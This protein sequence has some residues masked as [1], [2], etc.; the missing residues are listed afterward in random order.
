M[1]GV[2]GSLL[3]LSLSDLRLGAVGLWMPGPIVPEE[4][5][6]WC[7]AKVKSGFQG[8]SAVLDANPGGVLKSSKSVILQDVTGKKCL[9]SRNET[10]HNVFTYI[11]EGLRPDLMCCTPNERAWLAAAEDGLALPASATTIG[12]IDF[13][14]SSGVNYLR[15]KPSKCPKEGCPLVV[16]VPGAGENPSLIMR[17]FC[18]L[19]REQ[20]GVVIIAPQRD[21]KENGLPWVYSTFTPFVRAYIAENTPLVD[22]RRVFLV[23]AGQGNE[24]GLT[25][26]LASPDMWSLVLMAGK[27]KIP[28]E[29]LELA[30]KSDLH[31][32]S[33]KARLQKIDFSIGDEDP[34]LS[35]GEFYADTNEFLEHFTANGRLATKVVLHIF[36]GHADDVAPAVWDRRSA[37]IWFGDKS[38]RP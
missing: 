25:A 23:T 26:A 20:L 5:D 27:F 21:P 34:V 2:I 7:T 13:L 9:Y 14:Q 29:V 1:A 18:A 31:Q 30:R 3:A 38:S 12:D 19:C 11:D 35:D 28:K 37:L 10:K 15:I 24:V 32:T 36:P 8:V 4:S 16:E 6:V 17:N 22:Q 33:E